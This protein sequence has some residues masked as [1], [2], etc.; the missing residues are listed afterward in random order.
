MNDL[1]YA[2]RSLRK[3][4]GFSAAAVLTLA[5]GIG[6][7]TAV[8][9]VV[10]RALLRPLP[11]PES[12]RL[13]ALGQID[14]GSDVLG[15]QVSYGDFT[16]LRR[17]PAFEDAAA[18]LV[19]SVTLSGADEAQRVDG[20]Q[21]SPSLF[22]L[23]RVEAGRGRLFRPEEEQEGNDRV[24]V[25]SQGL[26]QAR[27]GSDPEVLGTTLLVDEEPHTIVGVLPENGDLPTPAAG[28]DVWRPLAASAQLVANRSFY[29]FYG[30]ARLTP[31]TSLS[32]AQS[33]VALLAGR[34]ES[35]YPETNSGRRLGVESLQN[36]L[37]GDT[38][39]ALLALLGAVGFVLLIT[40]VN[41]VN[42]L[43]SRYGARQ[44]ELALRVALGAARL[45][46]TRSLI[47]E[48]A[49]LAGA[50]AG[51]GVLVAAWGVELMARL[52]ADRLPRFT[53]VE[54]DARLLVASG[55]IGLFSLGMASVAPLVALRREN[56]RGALQRL[57]AGAVGPAGRRFRSALVGV[58][59]GL[60]F[61]LLAGAGLMIA[62]VRNAVSGDPGFAREN[63]LTARVGIPFARYP[64]RMTAFRFFE[65]L[66]REV[67]AIPGVTA[68]GVTG[69]LPL[70][71]D[72]SGAWFTRQDR[73]VPTGQVPP[74]V[75]YAMVMPGYFAALGVPILA[76]RAL[77]RS[78]L[79]RDTHVAVINQ[80]AALRFFPGENPVG[81]HIELG[82][83][84]GDWHEIVG[85]AGDFR[86]RG[87]AADPAPTAYDLYGQH[88]DLSMAMVVRTAVDPGSVT[89]ALRS[90]LHDM[91][92]AVPLYDVATMDVRGV[93][94]V[95]DRSFVLALLGAFAAIALVLAVV[96]IYGVV[97]AV[98][99]QRQRELGVRM[100]LGATPRAL[101]AMVLAA[102][103]TIAGSGV[104]VGVVATLALSRLL[105]DQLF[106]VE[107]GDPRVFAAVA[108]LLVLVALLACAVPARRASR[109]D[110]MTVLRHE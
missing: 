102:G 11:Y 85:V 25:I 8:F 54:V 110:P 7:T 104:A 94:S 9:S 40:S 48:I 99:G 82:P 37:V 41:L 101:V 45:R 59:V 23:L 67:E 35:A 18:M 28:A 52:G 66:A 33:Q 79:E 31:T 76:G 74:D 55:V 51:L 95:A 65:Q 17:L 22:Q 100:A 34:L 12:Q 10:D 56:L 91:D 70:S 21:V 61:V 88:W 44:R 69:S 68:V 36:R 32:A 60:A 92:A 49:L 93:R 106:G 98:V 3:S 19:G 53:R 57:G 13:V 109:I 42:L 83:P 38:R 2:L 39:P 80:S 47:A 105:T 77:E 71:G 58:Q 84:S 87:L 50:G 86:H 97:A 64:D 20:R 73:P 107:P 96:G 29:G 1:R 75:D 5:L 26:W 108:T 27:F 16:D 90:R 6:A 24:V 46:V 14:P 72:R 63:L 103:A 43:L 81:K 4:P 15:P 78:D 62:T 30:F 89:G